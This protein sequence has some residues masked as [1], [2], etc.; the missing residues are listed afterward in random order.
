M[1]ESGTACVGLEG[2]GLGEGEEGSGRV[3]GCL[4]V[5][6]GQCMGCTG[7]CLGGWWSWPC[8]VFVWCGQVTKEDE[9]HAPRTSHMHRRAPFAFALC[10]DVS[11]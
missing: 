11:L 3:M 6:P 10:R 9:R 4:C 1:S 8:A 2:L 7:V 5:E